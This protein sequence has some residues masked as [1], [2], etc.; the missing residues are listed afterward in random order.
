M[1]RMR[2][3]LHPLPG[4]LVAWREYCRDRKCLPRNLRTLLLGHAQAAIAKAFNRL[5][6]TPRFRTVARFCATADIPHL[7]G[8]RV[9]MAPRTIRF[10]TS[11]VGAGGDEN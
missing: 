9:K 2:I 3:E 6:L 1:G 11:H 8:H 7:L 5:D 10:V 4:C